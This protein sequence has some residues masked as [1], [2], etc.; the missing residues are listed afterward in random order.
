MTLKISKN[1]GFTLIELL[2]VITIIGILTT[3]VLQSLSNSRARAYDSKVQQQFFHF[4]TAA[5]IYESNN[6]GYGPA[7]VGCS[8]GIFSSMSPN[9]GTP[10]IYV[11][12]G[13]LPDY[14]TP[15]CQSSNSAYALKAN[16]YSGNQ[17]W[18]VDSKGSARVIPGP[19]GAP[20]TFCP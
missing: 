3:V 10:G 1:S 6:N 15:V 14:A 4:M 9:D 11:A 7:T 20:S 2:M 18:C 17:H 12:P 5:E 16:L 19:V 13:N 8:G